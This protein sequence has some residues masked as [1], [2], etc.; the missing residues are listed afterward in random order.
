MLALAEGRIRWCFYP[1]GTPPDR[2]GKGIWLG[3]FPSEEDNQPDSE[4]ASGD[5]SSEDGSRQRSRV[6]RDAGPIAGSDGSED[7][8]EDDGEASEVERKA[9]E[10]D[11]GFFA[12]LDMG[13]DDVEGEE[14]EESSDK[15]GRGR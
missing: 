7:E 12:A 9:K 13:D 2:Q 1:P 8:S 11:R 6:K 14:D 10:I 5:S 3:D 15:E 4:T